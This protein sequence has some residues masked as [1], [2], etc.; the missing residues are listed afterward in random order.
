[1]LAKEAA[2]RLDRVLSTTKPVCWMTGFGDSSVDFVLRFWISDPQNG[3]TNIRGQVLIA[4]WDT[5]KANGVEFPFPHREIIMR[6]P[7]ELVDGRK[8]EAQ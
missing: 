8:N 4:L 2:A 3:L 5:F 6:T 1:E 7:V